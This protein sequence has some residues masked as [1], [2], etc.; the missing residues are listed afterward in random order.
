MDLGGSN[1]QVTA[2]MPFE[3]VGRVIAAPLPKLFRLSLVC[4]GMSVVKDREST[5]FSVSVFVA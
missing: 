5:W 2:E 1:V 4:A 3:S